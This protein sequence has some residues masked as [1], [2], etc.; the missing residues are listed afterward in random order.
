MQAQITNK[1]DNVIELDKS[2]IDIQHDMKPTFNE[3]LINT[4]FP[5]NSI[6][7]IDREN[8]YD[9]EEP[10][11]ALNINNLTIPQLPITNSLSENI[12]LPFKCTQLQPTTGSQDWDISRHMDMI[13]NPTSTS[14]DET[15]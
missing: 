1:S 7:T 6:V 12:D 2:S 13:Y 4:T 5:V 15:Q 10:H 14:T 9:M 11:H 8:I 3:V